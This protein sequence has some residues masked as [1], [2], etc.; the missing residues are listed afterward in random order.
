MLLRKRLS[1]FSALPSIS[2]ICASACDGDRFKLET[3]ALL[4]AVG[5]LGAPSLS[6]EKKLFITQ[7]VLAVQDIQAKSIGLMTRE[8]MPSTCDARDTQQA[9]RSNLIKQSAQ[10]YSANSHPS[11]GT[12]VQ[13]CDHGADGTNAV[14]ADGGPAP[15][16]TLT[17]QPYTTIIDQSCVRACVRAYV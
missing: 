7:A 16:C 15:G 3:C 5:V 12:L 9:R 13:C 17:E 1:S 4:L 10:K 8:I 14:F 11:T 6:P 2:G